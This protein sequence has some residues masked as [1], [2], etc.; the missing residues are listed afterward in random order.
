MTNREIA[1]LTG[2]SES[3]IGTI[4]YRTLRRLRT[5]WDE[6]GSQHG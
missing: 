2:V 1:G 5:L 6:G 4:F 3:N